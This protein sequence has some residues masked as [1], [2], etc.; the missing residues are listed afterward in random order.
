MQIT[1]RDFRFTHRARLAARAEL[2]EGERQDLRRVRSVSRVDAKTV[3]V[4]LRSRYSGWRS[5]FGNVLPAHALAGGDLTK[6]WND[7]IDN[8][9]TRRAIGSGPFL[10]ESWDRG[11]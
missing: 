5:L 7:Q 1:A 6:V 10:L 4:V 3:R 11:R 2:S 8:P 9:K